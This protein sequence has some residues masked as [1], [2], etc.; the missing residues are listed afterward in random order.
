MSLESLPK[1]LQKAA[2]EGHASPIMAWLDAG[3]GHPDATFDDSE[4]RGATLLILA[5]GC[6]HVE[7]VRLL[8]ERG[9]TVDVQTSRGDTALMAAA[10]KNRPDV[11]RMLLQAGAAPG[12][13]DFEDRSAPYLALQ[14]GHASV[15]KA[16]KDH[17]VALR[18]A[19]R[20]A[21]D[22]QSINAPAPAEAPTASVDD[23]ASAPAPAEA[24]GMVERA[25]EAISQAADAI[26][27]A[28]S[29][30]IEDS[31]NAVERATG[32]DLD[33]DGDVGVKGHDNAVLVHAVGDAGTTEVL[34]QPEGSGPT[35]PATADAAGA[36]GGG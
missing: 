5:S 3:E 13:R 26:V 2:W 4:L 33:G 31:T 12:L 14:A 11:V 10:Y 1:R 19:Q 20:R 7:V 15:V 34:P 6:G 16:F 32:L 28:I 36:M 18:E 23:G 21:K 29:D 22:A 30:A 9:A 24:L 17:A 35:L 27:G 25:G 8:L